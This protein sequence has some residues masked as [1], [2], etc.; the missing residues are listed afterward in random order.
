MSAIR[1]FEPY[2]VRP[3]IAAT[4]RDIDDNTSEILALRR[5]NTRLRREKT[6]ALAAAEAERAESARLRAQNLELSTKLAEAR[7]SR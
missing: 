5:E 6:Q 1:T 4:V 7:W 3:S 2:A